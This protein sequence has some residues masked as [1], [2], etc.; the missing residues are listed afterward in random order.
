MSRKYRSLGTSPRLDFLSRLDGS[1]AKRVS[2]PKRAVFET[3]RRKLSLD[4]S[5]GVHIL[6]VVEQSS[7]ES[8]SRVCAK[9]PIIT[10]ILSGWQPIRGM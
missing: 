10:V 2:T 7:L 9:T 1:T 5:T 6:L 8:Q 3:S 4:V